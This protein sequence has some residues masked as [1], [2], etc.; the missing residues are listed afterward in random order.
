[1]KVKHTICPSCSVGCG[2]N[3]LIQDK[4]VVG[5]YP[6]KRHPVNQGKNCMK[7][8]HSF[9][10]IN[11]TRIK[12]PLI[13]SG[14][15]KK[16]IWDEALDLAASKI[17]SYKPEEIGI[18][19]S[20]KCTNEDCQILKEFADAIGVENKGF[21]AGELKPQN[22]KTASLDELEKSEFILSIGDPLNENPLIGRRILKAKDNGAEIITV[23]NPKKTTTGLNS[24]E[25]F[26]VEST[27]EF[28]DKIDPEILKK[29]KESSTIV[30]THLDNS[31]DVGKVLEISKN[32]E[33]NLIFVMKDCNTK[34]ASGIL[35]D[36]NKKELNDLIQKVK[37]LYVVG[38]DPASYAKDS[39][40][41]LEF[42]ITQDSSINE[43]VLM[44][45]VVFPAS[46]WAEKTGSFTDTTGET[47]KFSKIISTQ[48][49]SMED[50]K[51][52]GNL[53]ASIGID[54][55]Q[56]ENHEIN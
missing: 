20:G 24:D 22:F 13:K 19:G 34:G 43:T 36:L 32:S 9:E 16:S 5:T 40:K 18:I 42:L 46:C 12:D 38:T 49:S 23:D 37:L 14:T 54:L 47:Q 1:M 29:L 8:R 28:L 6:Y 48:D 7:G 56:P 53:A 21:Y 51:I 26:E 10:Q 31:D 3:L 33:S 2:I 4:K 30:V 50:Q 52:I 41:K 55:Q 39:L 25:Y 35:P 15:L 11:E 27:S 17:K 44:S 45:D